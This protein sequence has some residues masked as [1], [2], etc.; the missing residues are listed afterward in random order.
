MFQE[1][2]KGDPHNPPIITNAPV[3]LGPK[4][5]TLNPK[6]QTAISARVPPGLGAR[7]LDCDVLSVVVILIGFGFR[8]GNGKNSKDSKNSIVR[9][10]RIGIIVR[11]ATLALIAGV[12][13]SIVFI[14]LFF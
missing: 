6:P 1:S 10:V 8:V 9:I 2:L 7:S 3:T 14:S 11:I 12:V 4:P 5:Y 13:R